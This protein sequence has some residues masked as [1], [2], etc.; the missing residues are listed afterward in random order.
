[1]TILSTRMPLS[2]KTLS[3]STLRGRTPRVIWHKWSP[4]KWNWNRFEEPC[5][6][7]WAIYHKTYFDFSF[8]RYNFLFSLYMSKPQIW[9]GL[10]LFFTNRSIFILPTFMS[11]AF[12]LSVLH[13][14]VL[15]DKSLT[16]YYLFRNN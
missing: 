16:L 10:L 12:F 8:S 9:W 7:G 1:M 3:T 6:N 13:M 11:C 15:L 2:S 5:N 14:D 4:L